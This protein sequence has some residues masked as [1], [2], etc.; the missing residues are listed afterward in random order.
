VARSRDEGVSRAHVDFDPI[1]RADAYSTREHVTD[2]LLGLVGGERLDVLR[3]PPAW[4][5]D[6]PA[7]RDL[8]QLDGSSLTVVEEGPLVVRSVEAFR[9]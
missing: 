9:R 1:L 7:D 2:V 3:P 5:V 8:S 4:S 6:A